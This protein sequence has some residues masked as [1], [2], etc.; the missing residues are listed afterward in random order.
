MIFTSLASSSHG[1][2]YVVSDGETTI[3]LE[4]GISFRRIKKELGFDLSAIRGCLVTHEH[5]DHAKSV[6]DII[7]SGVEVFAS[8]GTAEALDCALITPVEAGVQFRVGSL[9]IMPFRTWHDA[10]EP[11][12]FLIYSRRDRERLVFATDTVNLGHTFPGV[13]LLALEAN[14]DKNILARCDRMPEKVKER[15]TN[16]HMEI[17]TLCNYVQ[18]LDLSQCRTLY[19]LHLSNAA[20][21]EGDF[22]NRVRRVVPR[23]VEV[24]VC[25]E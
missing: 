18:S 13:N 8:V 24:I 7:K 21:N 3:L 16:S 17:E 6:L 5:K 2:C 11:L 9:E 14:Y 1:N 20:S 12:G 25:A 22:V 10:K 15:I 19:L 23:H 4:C